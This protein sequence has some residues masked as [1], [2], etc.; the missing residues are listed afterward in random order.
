MPEGDSVARVAGRLERQLVGHRITASDLR[1]PRFATADLA[2]QVVTASLSRGKH[3]LLRTDAGLTLHTHLRMQGSWTV[4]GPGK[5]LPSRV[6]DRARVL[7]RLEDGR[8]AVALD[9]PVVEVLPTSRE[10]DVVG[11]LG[12]DL[13]DGDFDHHLAVPRLGRDPARPIVAAVLDQRNV[14]GAGNLWTVE[15]LFLRGVYPWAPAGDVALDP[16]VDLL[17]RLLLSGLRTGVMVTTGDPR[18]GHTH[19]VYGRAGRPCRRC[20][21]PVAFRPVAG[22]PVAGRPAQVRTAAEAAGDRETW[23]CPSCQPAAAAS[24]LRPGVDEPT[25]RPVPTVA[26]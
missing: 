26:R 23:W 15:A 5:R 3:L 19:W 1:V 12:P 4:L 6:A 11:H 14:A 8:T 10:A 17:Q 22:E 25:D 13:L 9:M 16:L 21:T 7:L 24:G 18:P 2:G 20:R